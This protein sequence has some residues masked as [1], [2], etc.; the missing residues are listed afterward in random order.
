[1]RILTFYVSVICSVLLFS[2]CSK[3]AETAAPV[4]TAQATATATSAEKNLIGKLISA[5][6][7]DESC[8][9]K[10]L[11]QDNKEVQETAT[12]ELCTE[13]FKVGITYKFNYG[14][15]EVPDCDCQGNQACYATCKKT[16]TQINIVDGTPVD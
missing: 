13:R 3:K 16:V 5:D 7:G 8:S 15:T 6:E 4:P 9:L 10:I 12:F 1:M 2:A 11:G 14:A